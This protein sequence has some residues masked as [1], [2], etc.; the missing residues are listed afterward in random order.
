MDR[1][2]YLVF[3]SPIS[4]VSLSPRSDKIRSNDRSQEDRAAW[5]F[6]VSSTKPR[7]GTL[8]DVA[9]TYHQRASDRYW[10]HFHMMNLVSRPPGRGTCPGSLRRILGDPMYVRAHHPLSSYPTRCCCCKCPS[11]HLKGSSNPPPPALR[12]SGGDMPATRNITR[13]PPIKKN[14]TQHVP[15]V[16]VCMR[17]QAL[18]AFLPAHHAVSK[19]FR[20]SFGPEVLLLEG[21]D[22]TGWLVCASHRSRPWRSAQQHRRRRRR[23]T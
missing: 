5:V 6:S 19:M 17:N 22:R 20:S 15:F 3:Q 16:I 2:F 21:R 4:Q 7:H 13:S 18:P 11:A 23:R 14:S 12:A 9:P 8:T 10:G 1:S